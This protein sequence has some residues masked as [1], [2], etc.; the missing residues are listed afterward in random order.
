MKAWNLILLTAIWFGQAANAEAQF[1]C[2]TNNGAITI[3]GYTGTNSNIIIPETINGLPVVDIRSFYSYYSY[4]SDSF[5]NITIPESVTN[6]ASGVFYQ[7]SL[8]SITVNDQNAYYSSSNGFLFDKH[9]AILVE[10]PG[11]VTGSY[12]ISTNVV[13]IGDNAFLNCAGLT[14]ITI[15]ESVTN[16]GDY[17]FEDCGLATVVIGA[18]ILNIGSA[19][20]GSCQNLTAITVDGGNL[21]YSSSS[22][23]LFDKLQL[24]LIQA[25]AGFTGSFAIPA[26]VTSISSGA[27]SGCLSLTGVTMPDSVTNI[28]SDAFNVC[29]GLTN[30]TMG[31]NVMSIGD[32]AFDDCSSLTNVTIPNKVTSIGISAFEDCTSLTDMTLGTNVASIGDYAFYDCSSLPELLAP[33]S[34][35]NIGDSA[36]AYCDSLTNLVLG[37][38]VAVIGNDALQNC[39][40]LADM[41]IP[42]SVT[43]IGISAFTGCGSM[44][45]IT[46]DEPN[47]FYSSTNGV[48]FDKLQATLIQV[49]GGFVG[50]YAIPNSVT[51]VGTGALAGCAHL[52]AITVGAQNNYFTAT[53]GV[54]FD[55]LQT[56]LIQFPDGVGGSYTVPNGVSR[57]GETAF[58]GCTNLTSI[59]VPSGVT[60]VGI[61]AFIECSHTGIYFQGNAPTIGYSGP[62]GLTPEQL[63]LLNFANSYNLNPEAVY[64]LP[65]TTG[66]GAYFDG[67]AAYL[68]V[69][70]YVCTPATNSITINGFFGSGGAIV[71]PDVIDGLPVT[72]IANGAFDNAA[73]PGITNIVLGA[74]VTTIGSYA[75]AACDNLTSITIP[76][77]VTNLGSGAFAF[78]DNLTSAYFQGNAPTAGSGVFF[79]WSEFPIFPISEP[80]YQPPTPTTVYYLP[81]TTGWGATFGGQPAV[82][83][84]PAAQTSGPGFGMTADGFGFNITGTSNLIV[85]VEASTN[86]STW[87]PVQTL[88]LTTGSAYFCDPQWTNYPGRY[89]R[90]RSP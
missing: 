35:T 60:N 39:A 90:F 14:G 76:D 84:N 53:N 7:S 87:Q 65:G 17:A 3:T 30:L 24:T 50:S 70:P 10:A 11:G 34:V 75:F 57:L 1:S 40:Q 51:N 32:S 69:P 64:Y 80:I 29:I 73:G 86:L 72:D 58:Y 13:D 79:Q 49:P 46:V 85:V 82:L 41:A 59:M 68:W 12:V 22:G 9:Q 88:T 25:P 38:N 52:T 33:N 21:S 19:A 18:N 63:V 56:L 8:I 16:I 43:S 6:I 15:P 61:D 42:A 31:A 48:L 2:F 55:K 71:I 89:Y 54:L 26:G 44:T 20:F 83:W 67:I 5:T 62:F 74:N 4:S 28:G 47:A 27:F 37:T 78:C 36:L 81:G 77:S 45:A 23:I 66:W